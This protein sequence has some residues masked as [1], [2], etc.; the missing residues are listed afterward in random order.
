MSRFGKLGLVLV[1]V[2]ALAVSAQAGSGLGVKTSLSVEKWRFESS[3]EIVVSYTLTN[4][5]ADTVSVLRWDTPV[6]GIEAN[7]LSVAR[8]GEAVPYIGKLV[9]R[10]VPQ[11]DD[12]L[13]LGPGESMTFTFDPSTA[14]DM[15]AAGRYTLRSRGEERRTARGRAA[16]VDEDFAAGDVGANG[17]VSLFFAGRDRVVVPETMGTLAKPGT[18][19]SVTN[20]ESRGNSREISSTTCL[21]RKLP[22]LTP[23][24]PRWQLEIE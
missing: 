20:E 12:Y 6:D 10:G 3:E 18:G 1:A 11:P 14:Y 8:D 5:G 4:D 13:E 17:E 19:E 23:V 7:I 22:K 21:I 24:S 15:S 9:K 16:K 2:S